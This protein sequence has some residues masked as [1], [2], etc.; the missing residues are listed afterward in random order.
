[1]ATPRKWPG[2][3]LG[4]DIARVCDAIEDERQHRGLTYQEVAAELGVTASTIGY[5]RRRHSS[6]TGD[7]AL[8]VSTW[9]RT[10]LRKFAR[11]PADPPPAKQEAA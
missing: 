3:G 5:W 7:V 4:L 8:R 10:D 9:L 11:Q 2:P 6:M 1:M